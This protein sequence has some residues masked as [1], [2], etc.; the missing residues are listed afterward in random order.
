M[1]SN[2]VVT[3]TT[4]FICPLNVSHCSIFRFFAMRR[5]LFASVFVFLSHSTISFE[6]LVYDATRFFSFSLLNYLFL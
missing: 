2:C 5:Q 3:I 1:M 4:L 6:V